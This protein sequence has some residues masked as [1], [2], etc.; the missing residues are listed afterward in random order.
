MNC[1]KEAPACYLRATAGNM[2]DFL[3]KCK[4]LKSNDRICKWT[5]IRYE[6]GFLVSLY[7]KYGHQR[8]KQEYC[9]Y[10]LRSLPGRSTKLKSTVVHGS[11]GSR[12]Q[13]ER[14]LRGRPS[15]G[16]W[17]S[18]VVLAESQLGQ[19]R[20]APPRA[21]GVASVA[22]FYDHLLHCLPQAGR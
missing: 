3:N 1:K 16:S 20:A 21:A 19:S 7:S 22:Q 13:S 11:I 15:E 17:A 5:L 4:I 18:R 12:E 8:D 10:K 6:S 2:A 14:Y 9:P